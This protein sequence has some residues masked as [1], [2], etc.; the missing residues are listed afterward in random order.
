VVSIFGYLS[1]AAILASYIPYIRDIF[2]NKTKPE[3]MSW[4]IW[5]VL[6]SIALFSQLAKGASWS[7]ILTGAETVGE[8]FV[9]FLAIKY[10]FGGFLKRDII[11]LIGAGLGLL[12]WYLTNEPAVALFIVIAIDLMGSILTVMK[13]YE[14]PSTETAS[15]WALTL[16]GGIFGCLAVGNLNFILLA[17]P[18]YTCVSSLAT[19]VAMELGERARTNP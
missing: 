19:L 17:F 15:G 9:F 3:R 12:L 13:S 4:L 16:L 1:G 10:G 5:A 2:L 8:L 7:L 14:N 18:L 11:A 6:G